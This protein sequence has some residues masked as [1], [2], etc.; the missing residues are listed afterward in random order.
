M[1]PSIRDIKARH[2]RDVKV[3]VA[4]R[5]NRARLVNN[6]VK[7]NQRSLKAKFRIGARKNRERA[8]G[9]EGAKG[10]IKK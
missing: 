7:A 8:R 3:K 10:R 5:A 1:R 4:T 9:Y 2:C 6:A